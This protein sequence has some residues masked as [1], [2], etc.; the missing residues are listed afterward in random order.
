MKIVSVGQNNEVLV[1]LSQDEFQLLAWLDPDRRNTSLRLPITGPLNIE[2]GLRIATDNYEL[3]QHVIERGFELLRRL[4]ETRAA[5]RK[6]VQTVIC[7]GGRS[8]AERVEKTL[9]ERD[10]SLCDRIHTEATGSAYST[11]MAEQS[12]CETGKPYEFNRIRP[13]PAKITKKPARAKK[14]AKK[15]AKPARKAR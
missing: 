11:S 9:Q 8:L 15:A 13:L 12:G 10:R 2:A 7:A 1:S 4:E 5:M 3:A 14:V 6:S